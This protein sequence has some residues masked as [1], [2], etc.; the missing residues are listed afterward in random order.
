MLKKVMSFVLGVFFPLGQLPK[1][2][3]LLYNRVDY[4]RIQ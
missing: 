1:E 2:R 4:I 3:R